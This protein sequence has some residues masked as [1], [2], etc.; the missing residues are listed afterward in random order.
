M[1]LTIRR[2]MGIFIFRYLP[3]GQ[4]EGSVS[5]DQQITVDNDEHCSTLETPIFEKTNRHL[6]NDLDSD[7]DDD[8]GERMTDVHGDEQREY[9]TLGFL[10]KY[11]HFAKARMRPVLT[12]EAS[13]SIRRY[14][15]SFRARKEQESLTENIEKTLPV[16]PRTLET[17]IRLSTAN[18]KLRLSALVEIED[19][20][21]AEE[22]MRFCLYKE[23]AQKKK[24]KAKGIKKARNEP[25][26]KG[27]GPGFIDNDGGHL[28]IRKDDDDPMDLDEDEDDDDDDA[29]DADDVNDDIFEFKETAATKS[30]PI[31]AKKSLHRA[32]AIF[33]D[34][35]EKGDKYEGEIDAAMDG[36]AD[37]TPTVSSGEG[38][39]PEAMRQ[40]KAA[41]NR[42][43]AHS[44][45]SD[46]ITINILVKDLQENNSQ[47][48]IDQV[49]LVL[50]AME[51]QDQIFYRDNQII[52]V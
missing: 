8:G 1:N 17:L 11:L 21:V 19:V 24:K 31:K 51:E 28:G 29:D 34:D 42:L 30:K 48:T 13:V 41:L 32:K 23:V 6:Y 47:L 52:F 4:E 9:L 37:R 39:S 35:E 20:I 2:F 45:T 26:S 3:P 10:K 15:N 38:C 14:Y 46:F 22:L 43:R 18:A 27:D 36:D 44:A 50:R 7:D 40:V 16:T 49:E 5:K 12:I 33:D 25:N